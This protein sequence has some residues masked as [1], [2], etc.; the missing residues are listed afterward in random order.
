[1]KRILI[2]ACLL[3]LLCSCS[4]ARPWTRNEKIAFGV[5]CAMSAADAYTTTRFL[6]HEGNYEL[7]PI[8]G[9]HPSDGQV[10]LT[11][12]ISQVL[13]FSVL[14]WLLP[15]WRIPASLGKAGFNGYLAAHNSTLEW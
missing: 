9:R 14:H 8:L 15:D 11:Q 10:Y 13:F 4:T 2:L 5:S 7:N 3:S 1:M 12:A 6:D